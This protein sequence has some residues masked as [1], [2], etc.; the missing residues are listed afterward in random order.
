MIQLMIKNIKKKCI[1]KRNSKTWT[2]N[3]TNET[4][5][6]NIKKIKIHEHKSCDI[7]LKFISKI[8]HHDIVSIKSSI[9][10][11][12]MKNLFKHA[13]NIMI[14]MR[15]K[16]KILALKI[17]TWYQN[18]KKTNR[19]NA[20][21]MSKKKDLILIKNKIK[22]NQKKKKLNSKWKEFRMLMMKIKHDLNVWIKSLYEVKKLIKYYINNLKSWIERKT[23]E[24]WSITQ[25][26]NEAS[27][28]QNLK[29]EEKNRL[30][31]IVRINDEINSFR[32]FLTFEVKKETMIFAN[33]SN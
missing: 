27:S 4:I 1:Q 24:K 18:E 6:I 14:T 29:A 26:I 33:Y 30:M 25:L 22:N 32:A 19:K 11:N 16:N 17:M 31:I 12:E 23:N 15:T 2:L 28:I 7:M 20:R 5:A 21:T 8:I 10:K 3:V 9:W 13:Q